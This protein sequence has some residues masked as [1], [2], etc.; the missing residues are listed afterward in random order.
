MGHVFKDIAGLHS[1]VILHEVRKNPGHSA[2][3]YEVRKDRDALV[4]GA[5][6]GPHE[7]F[8]VGEGYIGP[9]GN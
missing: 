1:G 7:D 4:D 2:I 9:A 5:G 3:G 6:N 8:G